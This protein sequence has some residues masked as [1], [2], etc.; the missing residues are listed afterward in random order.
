VEAGDRLTFL[1]G[2]T[3]LGSRIVDDPVDPAQ[4]GWVADPSLFQDEGSYQLTYRH[5]NADGNDNYSFALPLHVDHT[6]PNNN[7]P[8]NPPGLPQEIIDGG[9]TLAY[10]DAH[11]TLDVTIPRS[12]DIIAGDQILV[13]WGPVGR[14]ARQDP[15]VPVA[16]KTLEE[17]EVE[18]GQDPVVGIASDMIKTL[19]DGQIWILYRYVDRTGNLGQPSQWQEIYVDLDLLPANLPAPEVPLAS[20]GLIDRADARAGVRVVVPAPGYDNVRPAKDRIGVVWEGAAVTPVPVTDFPMAIF[21]PWPALSAGGATTQRPVKVRYNV[22]RGPAVTPS[23]EIDIEVDFTVAGADPDPDPDP[24]GPDP[25]NDKLPLVVVKSRENPS[26]DNVLGPADKG[27]D[28]TAHVPSTPVQKDEVLRLYWGALKPHVAEITVDAQQPTDPVEFTIPWAKIQEGGYSEK[29]PVYY[30]TWNGVN[31]QESPRT[32]VDVRIVDVIGLQDVVFPDRYIP[33]SGP[34]PA[35]PLINCCSLA[36]NGVK[37]Q[38]PGDAVNFAVGD[39]LTVGWQAY[40]DRAGT[41]PIPG[42]DHQFP[43][44]TLDAD[45]VENGI[46]VLIP[47]ANHVEPIV[48]SGSG[49]VTYELTKSSGQSGAHVTLVRVSRVLGA[50]LC[51]AD[52]PGHCE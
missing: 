23:P 50:G 12:S 49:R 25:I 30:A 34:E 10:L 3:L 7:L 32:E 29:L 17:P 31:E 33:P 43:A 21:V 11:P 20:D 51:S 5:L 40:E 22:V 15:T 39:T 46:E 38:V 8:G 18:S 14:M 48:T 52:Y 41:V 16:S 4:R 47:Y 35:I 6:P 2:E 13:Y 44:E 36:W 1:I 37:V 19:Q 28:A 24:D 27:Q 26:V 42:T 9:L 45:A